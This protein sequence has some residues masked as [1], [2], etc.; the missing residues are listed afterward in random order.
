MPIQL[1]H[2]PE[3]HSVPAKHHG[4]YSQ[5]CTPA[6][7]PFDDFVLPHRFKG[8][9]NLHRG[10]QHLAHAVNRPVDTFNVIGDV[11]K[12]HQHL[13]GNNPFMKAHQFVADIH[14]W[15]NG[16]FQQQQLALQFVKVFHGLQAGPVLKNGRLQHIEP[17]L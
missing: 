14:Y 3:I 6:G 10:D 17:C 5:D 16:A 1:R 8:Q 12:I 4:G 7:Q 15:R 9:V 11:A 2:V 13:L